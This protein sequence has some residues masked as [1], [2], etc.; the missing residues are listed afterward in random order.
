MSK[1][2][3]HYEGE[4]GP[5]H[6]FI[7][8][9]AGGL[10]L[11]GR[12]LGDALV[13]FVE[14]YNRKHGS[15]AYRGGIDTSRLRL[16]A[17]APNPLGA[18]AAPPT[19][20][21]DLVSNVAVDPAV[22]HPGCDVRVEERAPGDVGPPLESKSSAGVTA[23]GAAAP[24]AEGVVATATAT[25][26]K[27]GGNVS[28]KAKKLAIK[29]ER[30]M[31]RKNLRGAR[32]SAKEALGLDPTNGRALRCLAEV[33][34]KAGLTEEA[35]AAAKDCCSK[36]S[37][38]GTPSDFLRAGKCLMDLKRL[39]EARVALGRAR[40]AGQGSLVD[41][42]D[43]AL[44]LCRF[45]MGDAPGAGEMY[46]EVLQRTGEKHVQSLVG[47]GRLALLFN[48][49]DKG[50]PSLLR[51]VMQDQENKEAREVLAGGLGM[52]E[53]M[54][55][56]KE[57]VVPSLETSSVYSFLAT[58]TKEFGEIDASVE[59]LRVA[60]SI[61]PTNA[62]CAL[63]LV[64]GHEIRGDYAKALAAAKAFLAENPEGSVGAR[65]VKN[66]AVLGV[67]EGVSACSS[68]SSS[69]STAPPPPA[70]EDLGN[71]VAVRW[72]TLVGGLSPSSR[73]T[74][75]SSGSGG[76][77]GSDDDDISFAWCEDAG[78]TSAA[79]NPPEDGMEVVE[80]EKGKEVDV[81]SG[82]GGGAEEVAAAGE[83]DEEKRGRKVYKGLLQS[84]GGGKEMYSAKDLDVL[85]L[86]FAV[87]KILY[88]EGKWSCLPQLLALV[89]PARLRSLMPLHKT[90]IRN[91][92]A[93]Y[94]CIIQLL[95]CWSNSRS[96]AAA[97]S[98]SGG[99][100]KD[101]GSTA[102]GREEGKT[103]PT[104]AAAAA[105]KDVVYVCGDSHTLTPAWH[106]VTIG[107]RPRVLRPALVTGLK[108]WHLRPESNF[109]PKKNFESMMRKVPKGSAVMFVLGEI[110]CREGILV[111]VEKLRYETP[112]EG[113]EH[114]IGIFIEVA[115]DLAR[116]RGL[117][118]FVHPVIPVLDET[119]NMVKMYN[120]VFRRM[121]GKSKHLH[122]L[123][124]FDR[125]LDDEGTGLRPDFRLDG[126]H[127][128][129]S[130]VG[131]LEKALGEVWVEKAAGKRGSKQ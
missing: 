57:Q 130:Y 64:H 3:L 41:E 106:E 103:H 29:A 52:P 21:L 5:D 104:P 59:L 7:W 117:R 66:R 121:V 24:V 1:I 32:D 83:E 71:N 127:L 100:V 75:S 128:G 69:S 125:L 76:G 26:A 27:A 96:G 53:G 129:P 58:V 35:F 94:C 73:T 72:T 34:R 79:S 81:G 15:E 91:E 87:V 86:Y 43:A 42:A 31:A 110:D 80:V 63:G 12:S 47:Y 45:S 123:D 37:D 107:G 48:Q 109:Y 28:V 19:I 13:G 85:A 6:T 89:E 90:N 122:W 95:S 120:R 44:A 8:R 51:A 14:S 111:A 33:Y 65:G 23:G 16:V 40:T 98:L 10:P 92:Q 113:A 114:T 68:S 25:A 101:A 88:L 30:Q 99:E 97:G 62:S 112:E 82:G 55:A 11:T 67:L 9:Q 78:A 22:V 115:E 70:F 38:G 124:F 50:M 108:H 46:M 39:E 20:A 105:A 17:N 56:F 116:E 118:V 60:A 36:A 93:Y 77:S 4:R 18:A 2:Y 61:D 119:R 54:K 84:G 102:S 131:L 126:T 49:A 74:A